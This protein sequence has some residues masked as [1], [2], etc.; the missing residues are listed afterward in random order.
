MELENG[1]GAFLYELLGCCPVH[2]F[3]LENKVVVLDFFPEPSIRESKK[4]NRCD[5]ELHRIKHTKD[6][7]YRK[8][9][10]STENP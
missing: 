1:C 10:F 7:G 6:A 8:L 9:K 4:G 2:S 3:S 5:D